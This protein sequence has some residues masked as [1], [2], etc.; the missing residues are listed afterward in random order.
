MLASEPTQIRTV[1]LKD[2]GEVESINARFG[3]VEFCS[4]TARL[5]AT[6]KRAGFHALAVDYVRNRHECLAPTI[7]IDMATAQ[8]KELCINMMI[9]VS[10]VFAWL[11][12]HVAQRHVPVKFH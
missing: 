6:L 9:A 1:K 11:A 3:T 4:G 8:G 10:T 5:T 12:H 7:K 2:E